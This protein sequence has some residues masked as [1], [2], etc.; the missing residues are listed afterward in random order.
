MS[1]ILRMMARAAIIMLGLATIGSANARPLNHYH[2]HPGYAGPTSASHE[3][4]EFVPGRGI[5]DDACDLPT[6]AC[7]NDARPN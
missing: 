5:V 7:P 6:S 1:D 2:P 3:P 4:W